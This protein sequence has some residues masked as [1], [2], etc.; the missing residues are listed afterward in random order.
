MLE[1]EEKATKTEEENYQF[2]KIDLFFINGFC[3]LEF[4]KICSELNIN[5]LDMPKISRNVELATLFNTWKNSKIGSFYDS[6]K[7]TRMLLSSHKQILRAFD[8]ESY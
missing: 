7:S 3:R 8:Q 2:S 1:D 5:E 6:I 4:E